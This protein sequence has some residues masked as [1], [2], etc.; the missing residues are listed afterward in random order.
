MFSSTILLLVARLGSGVDNFRSKYRNLLPY[1]VVFAGVSAF[2]ANRIEP[3]ARESALIAEMQAEDGVVDPLY[4]VAF[5]GW[6]RIDDSLVWLRLMG[7]AFGVIALGAS[8]SVMRGLGGVHATPGG[9]LLLALSPVFVGI[10]STMTSGSLALA[11]AMLCFA[12]FLEF[13]KTG[14]SWWVGAWLVTALFCVAAHLGL[15][16]VVLVQ[17]AA[18]LVYGRRLQHR[19]RVW[20]AAQLFVV[21]IVLLLHRRQLGE[22]WNTAWPWPPSGMPMLGGLEGFGVILLALLCLSG[23]WNCRDVRRDPRHG[24]LLVT[25]LLPLL[26][27][28]FY[29]NDLPLLVSLPFLLVLTSMGIRW[30]P[31]WIRQLVWCGLTVVYAAN[32]WRLFS[33]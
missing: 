7:V 26:A 27:W 13:S 21:M 14:K 1:L 30:Y 9:M 3:L 8:Q 11:A 22:I 23:A 29:P 28:L 12:A 19:Q 10:G 4:V 32:Y 25:V 17:N 31:R 24:L 20:W 6:S 15:V 18:L 16:L 5:D 33:L 2:A